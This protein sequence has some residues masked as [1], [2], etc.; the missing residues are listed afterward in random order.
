MEMS[1]NAGNMPAQKVEIVSPTAP[2]TDDT[3]SKFDIDGALKEVQEKSEEE[4][5]ISTAYKWASRAIACFQLY[6]K[7]GKVKWLIPGFD[8]FGESLEHASKAMNGG[9]TVEEIQKEVD[10]YR[11]EAIQKMQY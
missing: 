5:E 6:K 1:R 3:E 7:T 8:Y 2:E 11:D 4:I 10:K 9:K